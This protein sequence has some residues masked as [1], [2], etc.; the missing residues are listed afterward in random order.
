MMPADQ[1]HADAD[2]DRLRDLW[3]RIRSGAPGEYTRVVVPSLS[4]DREE[5]SK[6]QGIS[7]YEER[8]LL[9]VLRLVDPRGRVILVTSEPLPPAIVEYFVGMLPAGLQRDIER[10]L[11]LLSTYDPTPRPLTEKILERPRLLERIR[12][13]IPDPADAYL[14]CFNATE[15]E[16]K[17]ASELGIPLNGTDP[18]LA[19]IGS[20]TGS[21]RVFAEACVPTGF[22]VHPIRS[23][24]DLVQGLAQIAHVAPE[25]RS[26]VIKLDESFAGAG[27]AIIDIPPGLPDDP[28]Q[29]EV[30][31]AGA[32]PG[33]RPTAGE[34][35]TEYLEK[36][37]RMGGIV[38]QFLTGRDDR[39]LPSPSVQLR[40]DPEGQVHLL[41][42]HDQVLGGP[43]GQTY[44]GCRFPADPGHRARIQEHAIAV[45]RVLAGY[46]VI[47]RFAIDFMCGAAGRDDA[48]HA[49]EINLRMGGTTFPF[50]A[51]TSLVPGQLDPVS[52]EYVSAAGVPKYYFA[53]DNLRSA[54]YQGLSPEEFFEI[55]ETHAL[56][57]DHR[58]ETGPVFHMIGALSQFGR[59]GVT[60]IADSREQ[61][62][63][64]YRRVVAA[65]DSECPEDRAAWSPPTHP[66]GLPI[67]AME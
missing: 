9:T 50:M 32:L 49:I 7:F 21:R 25:A 36:L 14:T 33:L 24:T 59:I 10:R 47:G 18:G 40:I 26:A 4:F 23:R 29:R 65:L 27:N 11:V 19:W 37:E 52:G 44:V 8:F 48:V 15:L 3:R 17:L 55:A 66:M 38:E 53:T 41:S 31:L 64:S 56:E 46:G 13:L 1:G 12:R 22:A 67:S 34:S 61:A 30:L 51:L 2:R 45:G 35:A 20:K 42:T 57:F 43:I 5:L 63:E 58:S 28:R 60:C 54:A 62:E 39:P 6:I 16:G